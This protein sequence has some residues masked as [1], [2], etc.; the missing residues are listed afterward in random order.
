MFFSVDLSELIFSLFLSLAITPP[1]TPQGTWGHRRVVAAFG[2]DVLAPDGSI[3]RD[4]LGALVFG[5]GDGDGDRDAPG[6]A[7][8][9]RK[10]LN[11]ATHLPITLRLVGSLLAAW[12]S[13]RLVVVVDMPLLFESGFWV[14]TRP[15]VLVR[16]DREEQVRRVVSRD[17][18]S[19]PAAR[20]RV[21]AQAPPEGKAARSHCVLDN[22]GTV[23]ELREAAARELVWGEGGGKGERE[24]NEGAT[25]RRERPRRRKRGL[26]FRGSLWHSLLTPPALAVAVAVAV[27]LRVTLR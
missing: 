2:P 19:E 12:L 8:S 10:K 7:L 21:A 9:R 6:A 25:K 17:G 24:G 22:D 4:K 27:A 5:G 11:A 1:Q 15:R 20:A 18:L 16:C 13:C 14:L 3:D 23:E 26:L